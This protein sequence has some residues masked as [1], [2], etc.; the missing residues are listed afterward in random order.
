MCGEDLNGF[1]SEHLRK[2][3]TTKST[4]YT[5]NV[6]GTFLHVHESNQIM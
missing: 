5:E 1:G 3:L 2:I 4:K 6:A